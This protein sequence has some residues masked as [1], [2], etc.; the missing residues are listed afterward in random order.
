[1]ASEYL[2][3]S[4]KPS[5]SRNGKVRARFCCDIQMLLTSFELRRSIAV[6]RII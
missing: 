3:L 1:M 6:G 2:N 5:V 4:G